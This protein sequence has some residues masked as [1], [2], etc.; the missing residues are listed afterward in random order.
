MKK[1]IAIHKFSRQE[2]EITE[3]EYY[4]LD[5]RLYD[6][7]IEEVE[8]IARLE[9]ISLYNENIDIY[10][11]MTLQSTQGIKISYTGNLIFN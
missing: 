5:S 11:I 6:F 2:R 7:S 4:N 10:P 3:E 8:P 9:G 1:I